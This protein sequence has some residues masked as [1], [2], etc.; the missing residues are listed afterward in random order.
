MTYPR[1]PND[2]PPRPD[3]VGLATNSTAE[4]N[5]IRRQESAWGMVP[6]II[7]LVLVVMLGILLFSGDRPAQP[8]RTTSTDTQTQ[9]PATTPK[10]AP[11][12]PQ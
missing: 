10:T 4:R 1:E 9:S 8:G 5:E 3:D 12:Q 11:S 7:G 2:I 6:G